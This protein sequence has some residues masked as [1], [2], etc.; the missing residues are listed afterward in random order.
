ME[1]RT[2][3]S[4]EQVHHLRQIPLDNLHDA[5][6]YWDDTDAFYLVEGLEKFKGMLCFAFTFA[7]ATLL[8]RFNVAEIVEKAVSLKGSV[9]KLAE[10]EGD[11]LDQW[12][13][14]IFD[15]RVRP[16]GLPRIERRQ[17]D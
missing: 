8:T 2:F 3:L 11:E 4:D 15:P 16:E 6:R 13:E 9:V 7:F 17:Q 14:D 5:T 12:V 1:G 10:D